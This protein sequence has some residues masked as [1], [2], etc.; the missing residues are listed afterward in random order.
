MIVLS[1]DINVVWRYAVPQLQIDFK[2]EQLGA[3][4]PLL[5]VSLLL[6][7][8]LCYSIPHNLCERINCTCKSKDNLWV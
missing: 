4:V 7:G 6:G 1:I 2:M 8:G 3:T 5:L